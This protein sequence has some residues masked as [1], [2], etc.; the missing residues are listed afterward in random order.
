MKILIEGS[1]LFGKRT[2]VGQYTARLLDSALR[3]DHKN[4]YTAFGFLLPGRKAI[5][6]P[7]PISYKFIRYMPGRVYSRL[8]KKGL[9][10]P[11]DLMAGNG[12]LYIFPN[13]VCWPLWRLS[14]IHI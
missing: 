9:A 7:I 11:I 8:L 10:P 6:A 14:L 1:P 3:Q 4:S 5:L 12:D 13:F 2:G